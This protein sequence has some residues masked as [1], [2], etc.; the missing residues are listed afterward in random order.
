MAS[1]SSELQKNL[2]GWCGEVL[3]TDYKFCCGG[4]DAKLVGKESG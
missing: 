1:M 4:A 3:T 2:E